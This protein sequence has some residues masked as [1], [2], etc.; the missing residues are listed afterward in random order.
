MECTVRNTE[1]PSQTRPL[2]V[3]IW[4][5]VRK[6]SIQTEYVITAEESLLISRHV[7]MHFGCVTKYPTLEGGRLKQL[8]VSSLIV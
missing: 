2:R 1:P 7:K 5:P 6:V 8:K 4:G 3:D